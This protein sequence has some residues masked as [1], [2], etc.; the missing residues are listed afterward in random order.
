M[1]LVQFV[2]WNLEPSS[3][4]RASLK[5]SHNLGARNLDGLGVSQPQEPGSGA[6]AK[7]GLWSRTTCPENSCPKVERSRRVEN[8]KMSHPNQHG[9]LYAGLTVSA[10]RPG[11]A[12]LGR[13]EQHQLRQVQLLRLLRTQIFNFSR[14]TTSPPTTC[15]CCCVLL[16]PL[17]YVRI[18]HGSDASMQKCRKSVV[19]PRLKIS[20]AAIPT[21]FKSTTSRGE[22]WCDKGTGTPYYIYTWI[23]RNGSYRSTLNTA[24]ASSTVTRCGH[25]RKPSPFSPSPCVHIHNK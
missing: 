19:K 17:A 2:P 7:R 11:V 21:I 23:H 9:K 24:P 14:D 13:G 8:L 25:L 6:Y 1:P 5:F 16:M 10:H 15:R 18:F 20:C 22:V 12:I 4:F 3:F